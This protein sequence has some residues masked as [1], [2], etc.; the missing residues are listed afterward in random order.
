MHDG[1]RRHA[2]GVGPQ[3]ARS[4]A[5][6][7]KAARLQQPEL[8]A[9]PAALRSDRQ[10]N[11][12]IPALAPDVAQRHRRRRVGDD[13]QTVAEQAIEL[14]LDQ[15]FELPVDRDGG[16]PRVARLLQPFD[17][18]RPV[19]LRREDVRVEIVTLDLL[20]VGQ[21]DLPGAERGDLRP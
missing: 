18:Q 9:V 21:D 13:A 16:E 2:G 10:Q 6:L 15:R 14:I 8:E 5:G 19:G 20:G 4:H 12:L 7:A 11:S 3:R 1:E 17:Q